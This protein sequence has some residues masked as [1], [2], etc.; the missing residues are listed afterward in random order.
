MKMSESDKKIH[1]DNAKFKK[2]KTSWVGIAWKN[3]EDGC[4]GPKHSSQNVT[5]FGGVMVWGLEL[6]KN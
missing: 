4:I 2:F 5:C 3:M 1:D 6:P